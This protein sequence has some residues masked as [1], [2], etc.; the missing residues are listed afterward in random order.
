MNA[1]TKEN[2]FQVFLHQVLKNYSWIPLLVL[3]VE[4]FH[5]IYFL[6]QFKRPD[7]IAH[8]DVEVISA[9]W[10]GL[11]VIFATFFGLISDRFCRK[12]IVVL[13]LISSLISVVLLEKGFYWSAVFINGI[14]GNVEP[15]ARAAYCDVQVHHKMEPNILNTFLMLP[16]PYIVLSFNYHLFSD[17]AFNFIIIFA[18]IVLFLFT[19]LFKD[20]RDAES[21][22]EAFAALKT[23]KAKYFN[24]PSMGLLA[25]FYLTNS[26]WWILTYFAEGH[27]AVQE[28]LKYFFLMIGLS[29]LAGAILGR[30]YLF[31]PEKGIPI[32]FLAVVILLIFDYL[33][34]VIIGNDIISSTFM[35]FTIIG[36][37]AL[38]LIYAYYGNKAGVH[39]QGTVYGILESARSLTEFSGPMLLSWIALT[40]VNAVIIPLSIVSLFLVLFLKR[41]KGEKYA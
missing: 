5:L 26:G 3:L 4:G 27:L 31:K 20:R 33:F 6:T 16:I 13:G 35:H 38:P 15:I 28:L 32:L 25:A 2:S 18:T 7:V 12:K 36:G 21:R 1:I 17:Y 19:I 39:E 29:F 22:K 8:V 30:I 24:L 23:L 34:H 14:L 11:Q 10:V 37:I 9:V 40:S 41:K